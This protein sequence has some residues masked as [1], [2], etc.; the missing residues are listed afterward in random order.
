MYGMPE[1]LGPSSS[2]PLPNVSH[3]DGRMMSGVVVAAFLV[4]CRLFKNPAVAAD[5]FSIR[6]CGIGHK[7]YLSPSQER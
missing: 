2:V 5:M 4:F 1:K 7:V 3:Q 6:R